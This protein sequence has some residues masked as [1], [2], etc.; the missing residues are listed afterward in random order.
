MLRVAR[1]ALEAGI[2]AMLVLMKEWDGTA[3]VRTVVGWP[4]QFL[5]RPKVE[6]DLSRLYLVRPNSAFVFQTPNRHLIVRVLSG[7]VVQSVVMHR[8]SAFLKIRSSGASFC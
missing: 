8:G 6:S 4:H 7:V 3:A 2:G 5:A 1:V